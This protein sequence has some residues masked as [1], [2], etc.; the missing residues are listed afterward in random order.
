MGLAQ[1]ALK[2]LLAS[3]GSDP[4]AGSI[5]VLGKQDTWI[6]QA[7]LRRCAACAGVRLRDVPLEISPKR[8]YARRGY[9]TDE[10]VLR[11]IGF[12]EYS[13]LDVSGYEGADIIHDL[14]AAE[15]P[16]R[17]ES[18]FDAVLDAGTLE[19]VF[20]VP[21]A[22]RA[23]GT[24]LRVGGRAVHLSPA[25]NFVDH[26]FYMFSPTLLWDFYAA[27]GYEL[28]EMRLVRITQR[29]WAAP[30]EVFEY[31]PGA[32]ETVGFGG[33]DGGM[34]NVWSVARKSALSTTDVVPQQNSYIQI[35]Q[36]EEH[37]GARAALAARRPGIA[38][39]AVHRVTSVEQRTSLVRA[40]RMN[41]FAFLRGPVRIGVSIRRRNFGMRRIGRF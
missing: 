16:A 40:V 28:C 37:D 3:A 7:M 35:W 14:N 9:L 24:M 2:L 39:R 13:S 31:V 1:G 27:N 8:E 34:F 33:L 20:H 25:S 12:T 26:G 4:L 21:N 23:I 32:M 17:L 15:V 10:S 11:A 38:R 5:L 22:L 36:R 29:H 6:T 18:R 19:H 30:W 41:R